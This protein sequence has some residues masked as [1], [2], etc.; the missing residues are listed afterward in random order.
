MKIGKRIQQIRMK[1]NMS[2]NQLAK[3]ASISQSTICQ[4]EM[5]SKSPTIKTLEKICYALDVSLAEFFSAREESLPNRHGE[6]YGAIM[7]L[8]PA[9]Q[10]ALIR[11]IGHINEKRGRPRE[12]AK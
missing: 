3:L 8:T 9:Q 11:V 4:V 10:A 12:L 7:T 5:D 1:K 2:G 6:L